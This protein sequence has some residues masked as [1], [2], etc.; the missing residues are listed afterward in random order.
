MARDRER[1]ISGQEAWLS[2]ALVPLAAAAPETEALR[3]CGR[4][5]AGFIAHLVA[6]AIQA[7]QTRARRRAEPAEAVAAYSA[8][9]QW[10]TSPGRALSR[11]L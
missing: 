2:K 8:L 3:A 7:P 11:A 1:P 9:G 6:T 5:S 4:Q 10:P